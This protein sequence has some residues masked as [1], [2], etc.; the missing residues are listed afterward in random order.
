VKP[1]WANQL[2]LVTTIDNHLFYKW[3]AGYLVGLV[4]ST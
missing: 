2:Q 1:Y 3:L 4:L